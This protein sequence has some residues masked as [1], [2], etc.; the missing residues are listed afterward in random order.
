MV[1][2]AYPGGEEHTDSP[3]KL[4]NLVNAFIQATEA[5]KTGELLK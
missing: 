4:R 3:A 5:I 1:L 2:V